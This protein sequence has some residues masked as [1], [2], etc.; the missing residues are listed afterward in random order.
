MDED[1]DVGHSP[2]LLLKFTKIL[3]KFTI[4]AEVMWWAIARNKKKHTFA[5]QKLND[6]K[7]MDEITILL[8]ND[9]FKI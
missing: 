4:F 9:K 7:S 6:D 1:A 8:A 3:F 2:P 5:N